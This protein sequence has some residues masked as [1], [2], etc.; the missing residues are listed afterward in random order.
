[1]PAKADELVE[2][3]RKRTTPVMAGAGLYNYEVNRHPD[4]LCTEA[5]DMI[6]SLSTKTEELAK[7]LE[8]IATAQTGEHAWWASDIAKAALEAYRGEQP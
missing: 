6:Q 5:A 1:M 2:R 4:Q 7:A 3:L 8:Q